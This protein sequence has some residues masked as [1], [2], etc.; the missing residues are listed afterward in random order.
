MGSRDMLRKQQCGQTDSQPLRDNVTPA[1]N[2]VKISLFRQSG[3]QNVQ[4]RLG[5]GYNS[6]YSLYMS[7]AAHLLHECRP[8]GRWTNIC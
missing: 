2:F 1:P 3:K 5:D 7:Q 8:T 4:F 6:Q